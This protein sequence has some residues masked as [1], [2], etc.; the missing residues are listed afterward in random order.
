MKNFHGREQACPEAGAEA[1]LGS[2]SM[3]VSASPTDSSRPGRSLRVVLSWCEG[4]LLLPPCW[5][6]IGGTA[7][8][9]DGDPV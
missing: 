1:G 9:K 4:A 2:I 8:G 5:P 6:A 7:M 3:K